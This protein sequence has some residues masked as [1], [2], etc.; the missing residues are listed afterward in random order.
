MR[1]GGFR[2]VGGGESGVGGI[3]EIGVEMGSVCNPPYRLSESCLL[4]WCPVTPRSNPS[5]IV[6]V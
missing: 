1:L 5:P 3:R 2:V 4:E 6:R